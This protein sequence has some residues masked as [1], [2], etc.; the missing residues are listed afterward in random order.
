MPMKDKP[1]LPGLHKDLLM[2]KDLFTLSPFA[3]LA[4]H[5]CVHSSVFKV[6]IGVEVC[7]CTHYVCTI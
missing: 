2:S 5:T 7:V 1:L 4:K 3:V 6:Q